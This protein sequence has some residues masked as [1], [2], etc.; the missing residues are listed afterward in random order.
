MAVSRQ[1][2]VIATG[3]SSANIVPASSRLH[4]LHSTMKSFLTKHKPAASYDPVQNNMESMPPLEPEMNRP[5]ALTGSTFETGYFTPGD[6]ATA[7]T[8]QPVNGTTT[9][10]PGMD[11]GLDFT[12][13]KQA[14]NDPF[15]A[16]GENF[17]DDGFVA[18]TTDWE[19]LADIVGLPSM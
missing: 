17:F 4:D 5:A 18:N 1:G 8:F 6:T 19:F 16:F 2:R 15:N 10:Y 14:S 7:T 11:T 9:A 12:G 3:V 13:E